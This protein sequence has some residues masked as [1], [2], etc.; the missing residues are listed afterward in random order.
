MDTNQ[1][2][3]QENKKMTACKTCGAQIAKSAK[4]CPSCGAKNKKKS[5]VKIIIPL[6]IVLVL[7][8]MYIGKVMDINSSDAIL[9]VNGNQYSWTEYRELY[10]KYYLNGKAIEFMEEFTPATAE[11]SG[12]ITKISNPIIGDTLNGNMPTKNTLMKYEITID[13][14]CTY[15]VT[16]KY[17]DQNK[18]DFSH[19]SVGDKVTVKG[20]VTEDILFS[21]TRI[22]ED[23]DSKLQITGQ[24]EGIIKE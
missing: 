20:E 16:Y 24:A 23:L 14:G 19:L 13:D 4:Q 12:E 17:Y 3:Q 1:T 9:T 21:T 8:G 15:S 5:I 7:G 22:E 6:L 18:F 11:I 10:H 2:T